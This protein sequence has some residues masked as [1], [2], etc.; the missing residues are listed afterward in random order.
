[1][2]IQAIADVVDMHAGRLNVLGDPEFMT[3]WAALRHA[4]F[5][6]AKDR[7][8]YADIKQRYDV[9]AIEFRRRMSGGLIQDNPND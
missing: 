3:W 9:A 2:S 8:E 7:P 5:F 6:I 4:L 1:M